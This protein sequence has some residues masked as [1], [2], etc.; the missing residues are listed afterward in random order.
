MYIFDATQEQLLQDLKMQ[1]KM[2]IKTFENRKI[3]NGGDLQCIIDHQII[4][5]LSYC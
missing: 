1:K 2:K 4:E 5:G 3:S